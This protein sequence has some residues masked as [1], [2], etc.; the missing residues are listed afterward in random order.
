MKPVTKKKLEKLIEITDEFCR[1][2]SIF[3]VF[4]ADLTEVSEG[5]DYYRE[6]RW[7]IDGEDVH[8]FTCASEDDVYLMMYHLHTDEDSRKAL[9]KACGDAGIKVIN[10]GTIEGR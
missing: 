2:H 3:G 6:T 8:F 10:S 5:F 1:E 7:L 4:D 9:A